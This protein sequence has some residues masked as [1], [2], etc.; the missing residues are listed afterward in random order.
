ML[1][2]NPPPLFLGF[3]SQFVRDEKDKLLLFHQG[4]MTKG[5]V[6]AVRLDLDLAPAENFGWRDEG[7]FLWNAGKIGFAHLQMTC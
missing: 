5:S 6:W 4:V 7:S 2:N 1:H 3:F